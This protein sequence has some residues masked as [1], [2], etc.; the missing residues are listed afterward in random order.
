MRKEDPKGDYGPTN[1]QEQVINDIVRKRM[2]VNSITNYRR[3][4]SLCQVC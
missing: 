3:F 2:P 4:S 1:R